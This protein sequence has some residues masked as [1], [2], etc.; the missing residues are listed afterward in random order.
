ML[1]F[2][3]MGEILQPAFLDYQEVLLLNFSLRGDVSLMA[4]FIYVEVYIYVGW[5]VASTALGILLYKI[6]S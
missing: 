3:E 4:T 6:T 2:K 5:T 1:L